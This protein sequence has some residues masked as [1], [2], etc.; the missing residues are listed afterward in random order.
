MAFCKRFCF[1]VLVQGLETLS[2]SADRSNSLCTLSIF[3]ETA[4]TETDF[5]LLHDF[6]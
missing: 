5:H 1:S 3:L 2:S 6:R 4:R